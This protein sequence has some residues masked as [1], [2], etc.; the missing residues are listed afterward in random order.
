MDNLYIGNSFRKTREFM[1]AGVLADLTALTVDI[2]QE[3]GGAWLTT[4][5]EGE[6]HG[7]NILANKISTGKYFCRVTPDSAEATG[8]YLLYWTATYGSGGSAETFTEGPDVLCIYSEADIPSLSDNYLS[9]DALSKEIADIFN[10]ETPAQL[11]K[12]GWVVSRDIDAMLDE[13]FDTPVQKNTGGVYDQPIIDAAVAFTIS[14][15]LRAHGRGE[16]GDAWEKRGDKFVADLL[17]GRRRLSVEVTQDEVGFGPP[18]P[19]TAN[20]SSNVELEIY[21]ACIYTGSYRTT[22]KIEI[23]TVGAIGAATF[24]YSIDAGNTWKETLIATDDEWIY[25]SFGMGLA[26]RFRP[27]GASATLAL[28]DSWT[29]EAVPA[30]AEV[31]VSKRGIRTRELQL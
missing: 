9:L 12:R 27:L 24:K 10:L 3:L 1:N 7:K 2:K 15:A 14:R 20:A 19:A 31:S 13:R 16:D 21:D 4:T 30:F 29:I 18:H 25:P 11:L 5:A 28:G 26:L 22:Y 17:E 6:F 23:D 8:I